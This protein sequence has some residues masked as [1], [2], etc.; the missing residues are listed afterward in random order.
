M[1]ILAA[2]VENWGS[3]VAAGVTVAAA[4]GVAYA[5]IKRTKTMDSAAV[6]V[7]AVRN[8][9]ELAE[10][11][12]EQLDDRDEQLAAA[13]H[14]IIGLEERVGRLE[15]EMAELRRHDLTTVGTVLERLADDVRRQG[16]ILLKVYEKIEGN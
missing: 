9:R 7:E 8:W 2:I 16:D 13:H 10:V 3:F 5:T 6:A 4:A 14:K 12:A 15:T 1:T 11:R